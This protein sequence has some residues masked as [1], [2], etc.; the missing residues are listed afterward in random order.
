VID[1]L[2]ETLASVREDFAAATFADGGV[3]L[4]L[5]SGEVFQLEKMAAT[6]WNVIGRRASGG[7]TIAETAAALRLSAEE[8]RALLGSVLAQ[9]RSLHVRRPSTPPAFW[10]EEQVLSLRDGP[11]TL[12]SLDKRSSVLTVASTLRDRSDE[13]L[14]AALRVFV[15][16]IFGQWFPLAM[17]ASAV[18]VGERTIMFCG[19]SGAGKTTTARILS[20]ELIGSQLFSEDVVAFQDAAGTLMMVDR[21][22]AVVRAW[23]ADATA[24]LV[25]RREPHCD[26]LA[27]RRTLDRQSARLPIHKAIFLRAD[28]R[29][30]ADWS[31]EPLSRAV[32]IGRLFLHSFLPSPGT[33]AL[34]S[35]LR[36]CQML[37][38][39]IDAADAVAVPDGL[40][41]LR[42]TS[43]AQSLTIAW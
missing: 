38:A 36:A 8:A 25:A 24:T 18:S 28:R 32:A 4:H 17:H 39:Q 19:E 26:V 10:D 42:R 37:A 35:H 14:A 41:A 9:A 11:T 23:M 16:K 20:E 12:M 22:E 34:R 1:H 31:L 6:A 33:N 43:R 15:P 30:G 5:P 27:L 2:E 3:L 13:E 7:A 29:R 21:V 40:A